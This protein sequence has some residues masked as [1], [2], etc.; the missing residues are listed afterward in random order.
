MK[1]I[2]LEKHQ[3]GRESSFFSFCQRRVVLLKNQK[4]QTETLGSASKK[5]RMQMEYRAFLKTMQS[6]VHS[7][8]QLKDL[9][10][11]RHFLQN[12]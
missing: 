5:C 6:H 12:I 3:G 1:F 11:Q 9:T 4:P 8:S 7:E 10:P 2:P